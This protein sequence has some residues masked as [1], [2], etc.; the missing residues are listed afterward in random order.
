ML[1]HT[2]QNCL[3]LQD[4]ST[5]RFVRSRLA[6][7]RSHGMRCYLIPDKTV[8][9]YKTILQDNSCDRGLQTHDRTHF[10]HY[11]ICNTARMRC[12]LIPCTRRD[13]C[14]RGWRTD[15]ECR[16]RTHTWLQH[17]YEMLSHT[18]QNCTSLRR[19]LLHSRVQS[20]GDR[21]FSSPAI[22]RVQTPAAGC[23]ALSRERDTTYMMYLCTSLYIASTNVGY[24]QHT[25]VVLMAGRCVHERRLT[26]RGWRRGAFAAAPRTR[27]KFA[28]TH[29]AVRI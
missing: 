17:A 3:R 27:G 6:D 2:W 25:Y 5:R 24:V 11:V 21:G 18:Q 15:S 19:V 23:W 29:L 20:I 1:S 28:R 14:D 9:V 10:S 26:P 22:V 7:A 16:N 13:S 8:Y 4:D 12:Y